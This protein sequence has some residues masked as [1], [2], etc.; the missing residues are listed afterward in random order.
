MRVV[1]APE[2]G[3][4]ASVQRAVDAASPGDELLLR[5][6]IYRERVV[7][8]RDGLRLVGED[9]ATLVG[10]GCARDRY[11]DGRE[12][13]TFLSATLLTL[14]RDV[15]VENL[16]VCNDAGD[17]D[18]AGQAVAVYAA[19]DRGLWRSCRFVAHQ[20]TLLCGPVMPKVLDA[21]APRMSEGVECVPSVGDCP[22]TRG[23]QCFVNCHIQGDVDFI[24]GR[25]QRDA[26]IERYWRYVDGRF[27]SGRFEQ[28]FPA[29][30]MTNCLRG[31]TWSMAAWVE[32]HDPARPLKN[33]KTFE[34]LRI[35]LSEPFLEQCAEICF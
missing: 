30:V 4:F 32:Y 20:D 8:H 33:E 9:G 5:R 2:G 3:D 18:I 1:I 26:F 28:R 29:Y 11:P 23:R 19:G 6:G 27:E 7:I 25:A 22:P 31:I 10:A 24:F 13:G 21:V 35:Y 12:K 14:G 34:R 15:T 16:T 17:G